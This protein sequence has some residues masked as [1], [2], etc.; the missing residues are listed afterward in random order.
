MT[1]PT[2]RTLATLRRLGY[3]CQVV[4]QWISYGNHG[5]GFRRDLFGCIDIL[6]MRGGPECPILGVQATSAANAAARRIK[7]EGLDGLHIWLRTGAAFQVWG[8]KKGGPKGFEKTWQATRWGATLLYNGT[9]GWDA[10]AFPA[11]L[12]RP[13]RRAKPKAL[14]NGTIAFPTRESED[15]PQDDR[16]PRRAD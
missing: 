1:S 5:H 6:A 8:W 7:S 11:D 15:P 12:W 3:H 9:I 10:I 14:V 13:R 4:E 2:Q 16:Q